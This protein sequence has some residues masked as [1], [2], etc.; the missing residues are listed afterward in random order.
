[1]S[2][3]EELDFH[4]VAEVTQRVR[5]NGRWHYGGSTVVIDEEGRIRFVI[6]KGVR[7]QERLQKTDAFLAAAAPEYRAAFEHDEWDA[8][9]IIRRF[10]ARE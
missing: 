3:D 7:T 6:G 10:H 4:V 1:L 8:G 9:T 5:R 2:P